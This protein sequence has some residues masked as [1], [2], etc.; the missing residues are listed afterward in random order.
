MSISRFESSVLFSK[1]CAKHQIPFVSQCAK[2]VQMQMTKVLGWPYLD[3]SM[4]LIK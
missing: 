1:A 4:I 3:G 2:E